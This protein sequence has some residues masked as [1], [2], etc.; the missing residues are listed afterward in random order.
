MP[1]TRALSWKKRNAAG[2]GVKG[3]KSRTEEEDQQQE[4]KQEEAR[5]SETS[6]SSGKS[7]EIQIQRREEEDTNTSTDTEEEEEE[8]QDIHREIEDIRVRPCLKRAAN[9]KKYLIILVT[10]SP[11]C[12]LKTE[13]QG[14]ASASSRMV[15]FQGLSGS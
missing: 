3:K 10:T 6:N 8:D 7:E 15:Y 9:I 4:A 13:A 14:L 11:D 1:D 12:K 5:Q 2:E